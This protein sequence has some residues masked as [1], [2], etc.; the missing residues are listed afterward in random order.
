MPAR[1]IYHAVVI[2]ALTADGWTITSDPLYLAYGGRPAFLTS[3]KCR[4]AEG[5]RGGGAEGQRGRGAEGQRGRG[6]RTRHIE[7]SP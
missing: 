4:G 5:Q 6:E 1:D 7:L 2:K 3:L